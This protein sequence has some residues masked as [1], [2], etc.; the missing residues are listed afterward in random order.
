MNRRS[1]LK[2]CL[3]AIGAISGSALVVPRL[4]F[5]AKPKTIDRVEIPT[6]RVWNESDFRYKSASIIVDEDVPHGVVDMVNLKMLN[7]QK[8]INKEI[9]RRLF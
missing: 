9:T 8:E 3:G 6:V 5:K 2:K 1:F 4:R 7:S